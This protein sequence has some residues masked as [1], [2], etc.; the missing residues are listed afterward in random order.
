MP[1]MLCL[2]H[3]D[4][5]VIGLKQTPQVVRS[6]DEEKLRPLDRVSLLRVMPN[7]SL[8][9]DH[10]SLREA[11]ISSG[12]PGINQ[13][14]E[15]PPLDPP[16]VSLLHAGRPKVEPSSEIEKLGDLCPAIRLSDT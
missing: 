14:S 5:S 16:I 1:I 8:L 12:K 3:E 4:F 2:A 13:L 7:D 10:L 6:A 15:D 11:A 9:K